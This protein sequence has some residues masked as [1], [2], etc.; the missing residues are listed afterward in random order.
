[1][2][3][4]TATS[5]VWIGPI[6][7]GAHRVKSAY[8]DGELCALNFDGVP[9][10]SRLQAAMD[11]GRTDQLVFFAFDLLFLNGQS[12]AHCRSS[13]R[14]KSWQ[15]CFY[16]EPRCYVCAIQ[17]EAQYDGQDSPADPGTLISAA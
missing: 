5:T 4:Q 6:D 13:N 11:K 15:A 12:T 1:L 16:G 7:T 9:M 10:F 17:S 2:P 3:T 8:L 14:R